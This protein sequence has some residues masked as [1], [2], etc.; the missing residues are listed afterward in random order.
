VF[1]GAQV[2]NPELQMPVRLRTPR[3][4]GGGFAIKEEDVV[5]RARLEIV[6]MPGRAIPC[7]R[8]QRQ[9]P[10][11]TQFSSM[12]KRRRLVI[13]GIETI[14]AVAWNYRRDQAFSESDTG[15]QAKS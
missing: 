3:S 11:A 10:F 15:G 4:L 14:A 7:I 1:V 5:A 8:C 6:A 2:V 12:K 13:L 9:I